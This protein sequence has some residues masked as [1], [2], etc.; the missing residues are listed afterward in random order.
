MP[1]FPGQRLG[2]YEIVASIRP[3]GMGDVFKVRNTELGREVAIKTSAERDRD[4]A[5][6]PPPD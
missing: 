4:A 3:G 5:K 2:R 6:N 1:L